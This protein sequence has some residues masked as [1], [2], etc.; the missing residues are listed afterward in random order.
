MKRF[1]IHQLSG[2]NLDFKFDIRDNLQLFRDKIGHPNKY[3]LTYKGHPVIY[4]NEQNQSVKEILDLACLNILE[5]DTIDL[6]LTFNYGYPRKREGKFLISRNQCQLLEER[7][8]L[9]SILVC[10]IE[11]SL[12]HYPV[13]LNGRFYD[14]EALSSYLAEELNKI[15]M[16]AAPQQ[17]PVIQCPLRMNIDGYFIACLLRNHYINEAKFITKNSV[18][19]Y[20]IYEM[21]VYKRN[22]DQLEYNKLLLDYVNTI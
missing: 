10:P 4:D 12:I 5:Q 21:F 16:Y 9:P 11:M 19:N 6:Y 13:K 14:V 2:I 17:V 1:I 15:N 20:F 3:T 8:D 7:D 18:L 22:G